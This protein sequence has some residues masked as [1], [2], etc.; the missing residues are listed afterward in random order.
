MG[1]SGRRW[2]LGRWPWIEVFRSFRSVRGNCTRSKTWSLKPPSLFFGFCAHEYAAM[3]AHTSHN[4]VQPYHWPKARDQLTID[5]P[6]GGRREIHK[7]QA[8][9]TTYKSQE[10]QE[11]TRFTRPTLPYTVQTASGHWGEVT[12]PGR[13][14]CKLGRK[15]LGYS[16][17]KLSIMLG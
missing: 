14:A 7:T 12:F 17:H 2:S 8:D 6:S 4:E 16:S 1:T 13:A 9:H 11:A 15:L 3:L 10:V 5:F